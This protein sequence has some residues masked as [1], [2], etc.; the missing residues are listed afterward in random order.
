MQYFV[1]STRRTLKNKITS[2]S[3]K[4]D[5]YYLMRAASSQV[6]QDEFGAGSGNWVCM[7]RVE[8]LFQFNFLSTS[9]RQASFFCPA[10]EPCKRSGT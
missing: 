8:L 4:S 6:I 3:V 2:I 5:H 7:Y 1:A 10:A 9:S